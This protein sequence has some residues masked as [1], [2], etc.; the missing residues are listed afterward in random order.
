M[1]L[2]EVL[3]KMK[4]VEVAPEEAAAASAAVATGPPPPGPK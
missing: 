1:G 3:T 2:K 4:I